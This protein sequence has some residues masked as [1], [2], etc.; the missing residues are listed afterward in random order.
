MQQGSGNSTTLT[1]TVP[2]VQFA[3]RQ[4]GKVDWRSRPASALGKD[5]AS[6]QIAIER[7]MRRGLLLD[8]IR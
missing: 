5:P 1:E 6:S 4:T 7:R 2:D 8:G 3:G